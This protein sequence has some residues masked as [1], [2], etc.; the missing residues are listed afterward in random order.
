MAF[1]KTTR[2]SSETMIKSNMKKENISLSA[3]PSIPAANL[4]MKKTKNTM[5]TM[6]PMRNMKT[7]N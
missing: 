4:T 6:I 3:L 5:N 1:Q 2:S 7:N